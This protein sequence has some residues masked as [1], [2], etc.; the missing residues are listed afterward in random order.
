MTPPA[1]PSEKP[2]EAPTEAP[3]ESRIQSLSAVTLTVS[4]LARSLRF[5]EPLG[6]AHKAGP[7]IAG[8]A[9]FVI[10]GGVGGAHGGESYLNL[11]EGPHDAVAGWGRVILYVADVDAF[12]N[13]AVAAGFSPEFAPQDAPWGERYFHLR[14]PD[15]HELSFAQ[16]LLRP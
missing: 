5:Y 13:Q 16:P 11:L 14:D 7:R 15:G 12:Y 10:G 1:A 6:F 3:T 8:F 2:I 4:D 9:S